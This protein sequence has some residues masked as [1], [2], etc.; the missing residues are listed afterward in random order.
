MPTYNRRR[1]VPAAIEQFRRQDW[2][3]KELIVVDDGMDAVRDLVPDDPFITY[4]RLDPRSAVGRKRNIACDR[5]R[6]DLI[7]HWDDD[8]WHAPSRLRLQAEALLSSTA[9][10]CG[11]ARMLFCNPDEGR[12]WE[13]T[14][15]P[16]GQ[17]LLGGSTLFYR[18]ALWAQLR[19]PELDIGED[20]RFMMSTGR[21]RMTVMDET[22]FHVGRIHAG[23]VA[24]K[25]THGPPWRP[26]PIDDIRR[27]MRDDWPLFCAPEL[28]ASPAQPGAPLAS[29]IMP[30]ANRRQFV[31][32]ALEHF[33]RQDYT[34]AE[35]IVVD[36][37]NEV[38]ADLCARD[39]RIRYV[40][41]RTG[42]TIGAQR[43]LACGAARGDVIVHWD[44]DDW[45]GPDRLRRQI[46]PIA[47]GRADVTG[48]ESRYVWNL[49]DNSFWTLSED[50]HKRMFVGNVHGGTLAYRRS[51]LRPGVR[52]EEINLGEDARLLTGMLRSGA[53]LERIAN[54]GLFVYVRHGRNAWRFDTGTFLGATGWARTEPPPA[55]SLDTMNRYRGFP[56][57][58]APVSPH[59]HPLRQDTCLDCLSATEM[60][61]PP[62]PIRL[63]RCVALVAT[64]P[65]ADYLDGA[66]SSLALF[67]GVPDVPRVVLLEARA[68]RCEQI[69]A[70]HGAVVLRFRP[71]RGCGPWVKGALYSLCRSVHANQY[72]CLDADVLV[73]DD[74]AP[75]FDIHARLP[76]GKVLIA[77]EATRTPVPNLRA[78]LESVYR[79]TASEAARL[80][81]AVPGAADNTNVINDGVF[82]AD[83]EAL[84]AVDE[85]L[86]CTPALSQWVIA[87]RDVWWRQK[88]ALNLVLARA[89]SIAPLDSAYNAQ[90]HMA[91]AVPCIVSG[92]PEAQWRGR[93]AKVLHFNGSGKEVY[94][95]WRRFTFERSGVAEDRP[96]V[97]MA[98]GT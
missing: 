59:V 61:L 52:Y 44:D 67:G 87:R 1:F 68:P 89:R 60:A 64:E 71:L 70:R 45:F 79:A 5:A 42:A 3:A 96:S 25:F 27:L 7:A 85:A 20:I 83:F 2:P 49:A 90:L 33:V 8:D 16:K 88:A 47:S 65:Y 55:M 74:V 40:R 94:A 31:A 28:V 56:G 43:N 86:R 63:E 98:N 54:D 78:G 10:M 72:L 57:A 9:D 50:L 39:P 97:M 92:R 46:E 21:H 13:Y 35:L 14:Y 22:R 30:T 19:F 29:C 18:R 69:A 4:L 62:S 12:A 32:L 77:P 24:P 95:T 73:L 91:P 6:G 34:P 23:N 48:L 84:A 58:S 81:E 11:I 36:S 82:V 26:I 66:L 15:D 93:P 75:L 53:R 17:P 37:G 80:L 38:V 51:L 41:A 76:P